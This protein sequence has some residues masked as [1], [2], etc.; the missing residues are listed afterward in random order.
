MKHECKARG[1]HIRQSLQHSTYFANFTSLTATGSLDSLYYF[2]LF[3]S[4][5][6]FSQ[7]SL[8]IT[9]EEPR[10]WVWL[11]CVFQHRPIRNFNLGQNIRKIFFDLV[12]LQLTLRM[13]RIF[14]FSTL[15]DFVFDFFMEPGHLPKNGDPPVLYSSARK[16]S[17]GALLFS[18]CITFFHFLRVVYFCKNLSILFIAFFLS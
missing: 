1:W 4:F 11:F 10:L 17:I 7:L 13:W 8:A 18:F 16:F 5:L 12:E 2:A 15:K 3:K 9:V 14:Y 6:N